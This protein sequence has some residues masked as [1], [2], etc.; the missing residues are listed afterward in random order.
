MASLSQMAWF[1]QIQLLLLG[2]VKL[3]V[4]RSDACTT[5]HYSHASALCAYSLHDAYINE[6]QL[7]TSRGINEGQLATSW[8]NNEGQLATSWGISEAQLATS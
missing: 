7:A 5:L 8:G 2:S 1:Q 4:T 3:H 6:G